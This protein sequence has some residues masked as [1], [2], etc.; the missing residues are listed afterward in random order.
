MVYRGNGEDMKYSIKHDLLFFLQYLVM[1]ILW[2]WLFRDN[3]VVR[4]MGGIAVVGY[5]LLILVRPQ[6]FPNRPGL[7]G[8]VFPDR[9]YNKFRKTTSWTG[10]LIGVIILSGY[11][12][13]TLRSMGII[14]LLFIILYLLIYLYWIITSDKNEQSAN[15]RFWIFAISIFFVFC[16]LGVWFVTKG[17]KEI[18]MFSEASPYPMMIVYALMGGWHY[19]VIRKKERQQA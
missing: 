3:P 17:D 18:E 11:R 19:R 12:I 1:M 9:I 13:T 2:Y 10:I 5:S 8:Q 16:A 7:T 4:F 6:W 15:K 14:A